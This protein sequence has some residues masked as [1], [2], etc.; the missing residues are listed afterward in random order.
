VGAI[1]PNQR[2]DRIESFLK[3]LESKI[4]AENRD[5]IEGK[6]KKSEY[7]DLFEDGFL[8]VS[9]A[10]SEERKEYIASLMKNSLSDQELMH[11]DYKR[12]L[13]ILGQ[14]EAFSNMK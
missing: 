14:V 13:S 11:S 8:Q 6:I 1:I 2:I 4:P 9:R 10:L 12:L 5:E 7:I 3:I